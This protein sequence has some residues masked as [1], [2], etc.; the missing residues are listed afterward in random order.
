MGYGLR[1]KFY[2]YKSLFLFG[3]ER[4]EKELIAE[5]CTQ[6]PNSSP[7]FLIKR[8]R[9]DKRYLARISSIL[10]RISRSIDNTKRTSYDQ[11]FINRYH[12]FC[13]LR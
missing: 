4:R 5:N 11:F 9:S 3:A 10:R 1:V 13:C 12:V 8:W 7:F 2:S 6:K